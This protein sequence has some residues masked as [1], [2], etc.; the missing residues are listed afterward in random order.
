MRGDERGDQRVYDPTP[1]RTTTSLL[2]ALQDPAGTAVWRGFDARYRPIITAFARR[3]GLGMHDAA[4]AA[5][6]TLSEFA[7]DYGAGGY[8]RARGRLGSWVLAIARHRVADIQ[9]AAERRRVRRGESAMIDVSAAGRLSAIWEAERR[10]TVLEAAWAELRSSARTSPV[11]LRAF[12]LLVLRGV[13]A[14]AV[15]EDCTVSVAEVYRIKH[16]LT[17]RLREIVADMTGAFD[18]GA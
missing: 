14:E 10:R 11:T 15:A 5:Q 3:L 16:R 12:E 6:Q 17:R 8:D 2:Q 1:T 4:E 13:P 9:R 18:G 7:R